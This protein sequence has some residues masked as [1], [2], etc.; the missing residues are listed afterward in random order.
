MKKLYFIIVSLLS[1]ILLAGCGTTSL[2][3]GIENNLN[4]SENELIENNQE[5]TTQNILVTSSDY[6]ITDIT[7]WTPQG[8]DTD[9]FTI[10]KITYIPDWKRTYLISKEGSRSDFESAR[11]ISL[12]DEVVSRPWQSA[13]N[14]SFDTHYDHNNNPW[15]MVTV[16]IDWVLL[17]YEWTSTTYVLDFD[18]PS[19]EQNKMDL[20]RIQDLLNYLE[21]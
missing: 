15:Y 10:K 5:P 13:Q 1:V 11:E 6:D 2:Q 7:Q 20:A 8:Y 4:I 14:D 19:W 16:P 3:Q 9:I 12:F 18:D 17:V 21:L